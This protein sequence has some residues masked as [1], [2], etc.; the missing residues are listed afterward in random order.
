MNDE[1]FDGWTR[2]LAGGGSR[3]G[4]LRGAAGALAA[5]A[6]LGAGAKPRSGR[7]QDNDL[8]PILNVMFGSETDA[9]VVPDR[10]YTAD[11][12]PD[13]MNPER[14]M[15]FGGWTTGKTHTIVAE[16]LWLAPSCG[17]DLT[18]NGYNQPGTSV[19]LNDYAHDKL[20]S[21]R[22]DGYKVLF[23]PRY[24]EKPGGIISDHCEING[25]K[26]FHADSIE[27]QK[28]HI[29]AVA[30]MLADYKDVI[31]FIQAGYLGN[32]GEWNWA[33]Y[34]KENAPFLYNASQRIEIIDYVLAAYAAQGIR[35]H[36]DLRRPVFAYEIERRNI[37]QGNPP[38]RVGLHNDCFMSNADPNGLPSDSDTYENFVTATAKFTNTP[39]DAITY[40]KRLTANASFGG[41]TC[42]VDAN[43][44]KISDGTERWR[45]CDNMT[46]AA[47]EPASLYM[48]YLNGEWAS[49]AV[50]TWDAGGCYDKIRRRLGYRFEVIKVE[51]TPKVAAG[52]SFLV[53]VDIENTGWARL[54]KPRVAQLV[55]RNGSTALPPYSFTPPE[56]ENWAPGQSTAISVNAPAPSAGTYSVRLWI[57]DPDV[58][59]GAT[60]E[61]KSAYAIKLATLRGGTNV[62]D[63]TTGENDLGVSITVQ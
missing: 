23:R 46:G 19:M 53:R 8:P 43:G 56:V 62:F 29:D 34:K 17:V 33:Y 48:S 38:A 1:R 63:G 52:Q 36:V 6:G 59:P 61:T 54:H 11:P 55:L 18:W 13:L 44:D 41:E 35:Q 20:E 16:W 26:V 40:A 57:P 3:R 47:S 15:Y 42:P 32:W 50:K 7:A 37:E 24:D 27:R 21:A 45:S 12:N 10:N 9:P 28:N 4:L 51:Y 49:D 30:A 2:R 25:V 58:P 22:R 60:Q 5:A 14:G 31:A 39:A